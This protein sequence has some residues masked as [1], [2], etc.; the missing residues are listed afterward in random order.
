MQLS[1]IVPVYNAERYLCECIDSILTQ[2]FQDF[3]LILIDDGSED[4]SGKICNEYSKL[5]E[6]IKVIH[7]KNNGVSNTRN[8]GIRNATG[9]YVVF[10][11]ADDTVEPSMYSMMLAEAMDVDAD[12]V[13]CGYKEISKN[14]IQNKLFNLPDSQVMERDMVIHR[15][16]YSDFTGEHIINSPCN[17]LYKRKILIDNNI[18]FP[19]RRRGEDWLFNIQ[20]IEKCIR[21]IYVDRAL[22]N[23]KR[24]ETSAM[25]Q[26]FPEQYELWL[27]NRNI[28]RSLID[29]YRFHVDWKLINRHWLSNVIAYCINT[30]HYKNNSVRTIIND[31]EFVTAC[32]NSYRLLGI[33]LEIVR[34]VVNLKLYYLAYL[35][36]RNI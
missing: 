12:L 7:Q 14:G 23:Y 31:E 20:Y 6:K 17:K 26:C 32:K 29:Y 9:D 19:N 25:A 2:T 3:E 13:I 36:C 24:N 1:V 4:D 15:L 18:R 22:Y 28:R 5:N 11:D 10:V 16:L 33:R 21:A 34:Q 35:L 30:S 8:V 27:E